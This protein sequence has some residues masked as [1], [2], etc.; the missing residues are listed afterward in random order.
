MMSMPALACAT[1]V[2]A[3]SS[4]VGS[5]RISYSSAVIAATEAAPT[6]CVPD[7]STKPQW[8]CDMYSHRHTSPISSRP[9]TSRLMARAAFCTMPSSAQAPVATSSF[10]SGRP[11]RMTLGMPSDF[12]LGALFHRF[13]DRKI[14]DAGHGAH[15]LAN[16][17]AGTDEQR[18]DKAFG[19]EPGFANE[20]THRF[21][22][23]QAAWTIG[24][25]WHNRKF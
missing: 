21:G 16:A 5:L 9:G 17:F 20:R 14:E 18:I 3:S 24:G 19:A 10:D 11:K 23:T 6:E 25:E 7:F 12:H 15:F 13:V 8:P 2:L 4:S 1:A 22:A